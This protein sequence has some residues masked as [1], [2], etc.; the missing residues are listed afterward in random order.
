MIYTFYSFKGGVGRSM[1]LAAVAYVFAQRGLKVLT[2][3][4]DLEAPGLERYF[5][6]PRQAAQARAAPG[7]I[8]LLDA[9][10]LAM[11]SEAE[12][13]KG[14]FRRWWDFVTEAV[15]NAKGG[16][17]VDL[18]TA[19]AREPEDRLQAYASTVRSFDW[20][21]FFHNW[22]GEQFFIW[23]RQQ[24]LGQGDEPARGY[25]VVLVDSRTGLTEMGGVCAY[26]LADCAVMF[27]AANQQNIDGTLQVARDFQSDAVKALRRGRELELLVLPARLE[28]ENQRREEFLRGF[29]AAF[30]RSQFL[31]K[32]L[33]EAGEDYRTLALPYERE[34][35]VI[36]RLVGGDDAELG[37]PATK[38][39][40]SFARLADALTLI[41][42]GGRLADQ[43][44]SAKAALVPSEGDVGT[45]TMTGVSQIADPTLRSSGFDLY[46]EYSSNDQPQAEVIQRALH[47]AGLNVWSS[48][49]IQAWEVVG[50]AP[51]TAIA[52]SE[53]VA[54]FITGNRPSAWSARLLGLAR[55]ARKPILPLV[56]RAAPAD[57]ISMSLGTLGLD[58]LQYL[59]LDLAHPDQCAREIKTALA[60][61]RRAATS[62]PQIVERDPYPGERAFTED[63]AEFFFGRERET[64][65]LLLLTRASGIALVVGAAGVGK[66]SLL[67]AGLMHRLRADVHAPLLNYVDLAAGDTAPPA[68]EAPDECGK[69]DE[70]WLLLDGIDAFP[71][72]GGEPAIAARIAEVDD[73]LRWADARGARVVLAMRD[74]LPNTLR[75]EAFERWRLPMPGDADT[76]RR[77]LRG[78]AVFNLAP[79]DAASLRAAIEKPATRRGHVLDPGL[80]QLLID[81]AGSAYSAITQIARVLPHLWSER[82]RGW[83]T[84]R[85]HDI[86][87]GVRGCFEASFQ[88]WLASLQGEQ[89]AGSECLVRTLS[90]L[91]AGAQLVAEPTAWAPLATIPLLER[92]DA[93]R[94]REQ[95]AARGLIEL[96]RA[97][98]AGSGPS[99]AVPLRGDAWV[100][101]LFG[102]PKAYG[103]P[104]SEPLQ[105]E[106]I[107]W[108]R[109]FASHVSSWEVSGRARAAV[110]A[111]PL[112]AEAQQYLEAHRDEL[113]EAEHALIQVSLEAADEV[114]E[115][116]RAR[117]KAELATA[118]WTRW[119]GFA[120]AL[121]AAVAWWNESKARKAQQMT[122]EAKSDAAEAISKAAKA[123]SEAAYKTDIALLALLERNTVLE[124]AGTLEEAAKLLK[125]AQPNSV[126]EAEKLLANAKTKINQATPDLSQPT[127]QDVT[128]RNIGSLPALNIDIGRTSISGM[129]AGGF[130]AVQF[131]VA[132]SSIV[133]GVGVVAGG[134]FNCAQA[135]VLRAIANCSCTGESGVQCAVTESSADVQSLVAN[136]REMARQSVIDPIQNLARQRILTIS[137][138]KDTLVPPAIAHQLS[139]F[140]TALGVPLANISP[141]TL[142]DAGHTMPTK[143]YGISCS[144][145][146]EPFIGK[147]GYDAAE[148]ILRWIYG[149][150]RAPSGKPAGKF[151][152]FD[153]TRYISE[154]KV[155]VDWGTSTGLDKT[156]WVYIPDS[157]VN[158]EQCR[159]HIVLHGCK[160]GQSYLPRQRPPDGGL[161]FGAT[162][163]K[164]TGYARWADNNNLVI[165]YPQAASIPFKNPNGCWDWWGYTGTDYATKKGAQIRTL[166]AMVDALAAGAK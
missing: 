147:C 29:E 3:D 156:G 110:V 148:N 83:L 130:M 99:A 47:E 2:I 154:N 32:A 92:T 81:Q 61:M 149:S 111:G 108:R 16:G 23:L 119:L 82:T 7:L 109:R 138:A 96:W 136:A 71:D 162:F 113:T 87:G 5:V 74:T 102:N 159:V 48:D 164:N 166:R 105:P 133:T 139:A 52:Q 11:T 44:D 18:M 35:A 46:L 60:S 107:F 90:N 116:E 91:D 97:D 143:D 118:R 153:Q 24:L 39:E 17:Y 137:G 68:A 69:D 22:H 9:Y 124:A 62:A 54:I 145:E 155:K 26:Q 55:E 38:A 73:W 37:L 100:R 114:S 151:I 95:M 93:L 134:P 88:K 117:T 63:D 127:A 77:G 101:L 123:E 65:D 78:G 51:R 14:R 50:E 79:L 57:A 135:D 144:Q 67:R 98:F 56:D 76:D 59:A 33:Y 125:S 80:P 152:Q 40:T 8:D 140:Y 84:L 94:L 19:G 141:V 89:R 28:P 160:Q 6:S 70:R 30:P 131:Q 66:T 165:L 31:P 85:A 115:R 86:A 121:A 150:L 72:G 157:C 64:S 104:F 75:R 45:L 34:F 12:F 36:E 43:K 1:A 129:S 128:S 112:L 161:Y 27:C 146:T 10:K 41:A 142:P 53:A 49:R 21:D 126:P 132:H 4:F 122:A 106:F 13:E 25:D 42:K 103:P 15:P 58:E 120:L 163:V 20:M 158:G